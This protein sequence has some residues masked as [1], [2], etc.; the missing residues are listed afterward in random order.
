MIRSIIMN[1]KISTKNMRTM[2]DYDDYDEDYAD[3]LPEYVSDDMV[4]EITNNDED[5]YVNM[6]KNPLNDRRSKYIEV[7]E[8]EYKYISLE[9]RLKMEQYFEYE[10]Y[11]KELYPDCWGEFERKYQDPLT[12]LE[13][14]EKTFDDG[15]VVPCFSPSFLR[16]SFG[17][18]NVSYQRKRYSERNIGAR[19]NTATVKKNK[20]TGGARVM[21]EEEKVKANEKNQIQMEKEH[22]K[23]LLYE[24]K[25]LESERI[26]LEQIKKKDAKFNEYIKNLD[27]IIENPECSGEEEHKDIED[28]ESEEDYLSLIRTKIVDKDIC[29]NIKKETTEQKDQKKKEEK[30]KAVKNIENEILKSM[31]SQEK[32]TKDSFSK[33]TMCKFGKSCTRI[34]TCNYAHCE[35]ELVVRKCIYDPKC[36]RPECKFFHIGDKVKKQNILPEVVNEE[37]AMCKNGSNCKYGS[38][39]KFKHRL[40]KTSFEQPIRI[41]EN[42]G[43]TKSYAEMA[44]SEP[45]MKIEKRK[46]E[47]NRPLLLLK[48]KSVEEMKIP[49][50]WIKILNICDTS[51]TSVSINITQNIEVN[52]DTGFQT[53][54]SNKKKRC[55]KI[56]KEE[57]QYEKLTKTKLCLSVENNTECPHGTNCRYAHNIFEIVARPCRNGADCNY[58]GCRFAH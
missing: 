54:T 30:P 52:I 35:S 37:K 16:K 48:H 42:F 28:E 57:K 2:D 13:T 1:R 22:E 56:N 43:F 4:P 36:V 31:F 18:R 47:V 50:T 11:Y 34:K 6:M 26:K 51:Q 39:C 53:K 17:E 58:D 45:T 38:K 14:P 23:K 44:R 55:K 27:E 46:E 7:K 10:E 40:L 21:T 8:I 19:H 24:K 32:N 41:E 20:N 33:T 29:Y 15:I 25:N 3:D 9:Y 12:P 5:D 49:G